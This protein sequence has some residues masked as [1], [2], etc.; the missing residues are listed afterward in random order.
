[1]WTLP[2]QEQFI[3]DYLELCEPSAATPLPDPVAQAVQGYISRDQPTDLRL[4]RS[5]L[6]PAFVIISAPFTEP[7]LL[8][9][10]L[11]ER[12]DL[13][14][15]T[16]D[17]LVWE[18][19]LAPRSGAAH[20]ARDFLC[21]STRAGARAPA[22]AKQPAKKGLSS[23]KA[24]NGRKR[25]ES[26]SSLSPAPDLRDVPVKPR[27]MTPALLGDLIAARLMEPDVSKGVVFWDV[28]NSQFSASVTHTVMALLLGLG[29]RK[30]AYF[31]TLDNSAALHR[32][33]T[34]KQDSGDEGPDQ[35]AEATPPAEATLLLCDEEEYEEL[36]ER[37]REHD[38][39]KKSR[40]GK[41]APLHK[42]VSHH[43]KLTSSEQS[44]TRKPS[45]RKP[46]AMSRSSLRRSEMSIE[47]H[48][49]KRRGLPKKKGDEDQST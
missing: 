1:M 29:K 46:S 40:K 48:D 34:Q 16:V 33:A 31:I 18:G 7:Y 14:I 42:Q 27:P 17:Q 38:P 8:A 26:T 5:R 10:L 36:P 15:V 41:G 45:I 44:D 6:A 12:Y 20:R 13:T 2:A 24:S 19:V 4:L 30:H 47:P 22:A 23:A 9:I 28:H 39:E 37:D 21:D 49:K 11:A 43:T 3:K 25:S 32:L 35:Q